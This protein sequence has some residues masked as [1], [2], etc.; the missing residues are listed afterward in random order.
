[1]ERQIRLHAAEE[2]SRIVKTASAVRTIEALPRRKPTHPSMRS[3]QPR[4]LQQEM[5]AQIVERN[6]NDGIIDVNGYTR[7]MN[8]GTWWALLLFVSFLAD[9][10]EIHCRHM[11]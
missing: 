2:P 6:P 3:L 9:S 5:Y 11:D 7:G 1:L 8:R 10:Y 4:L